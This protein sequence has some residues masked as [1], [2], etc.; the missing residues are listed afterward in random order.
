MT[1]GRIGGW[2]D[3]R[4][5][6]WCVAWRA[7]A[8]LTALLSAYPPI[9]LSAQ[10]G[11]NPGASPYHDLRRGAMVR[12]VGGYLGGE[13]GK[14]PV[15]ASHGWTGG[16]RF[17]YQASNVIIFT[18]GI[19]YARTDAFYVTARESP[20]DTVGPVNSALVLADAGLQISLTGGKTFHGLQP[21]IGGTVGLAFGSPIAAD[22]S[23]YDFG[24]KVTAGPEAG[25]RWY[26]GR[27]VSF[28]L[29]GRIVYYRLQYPAIYRLA[30]LPP[31]A[32]LTEWTAHP[33][34]TFGVAWTF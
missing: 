28:E 22:T 17:E 2:A 20:P 25:I 1:D 32:S 19:A 13:R 9:R 7:V 3:R 24:T 14:V 29:G 8:C 31:N 6:G 4:I 15:G 27:R 5:G 11:H 30:L 21:Y 23:G 34:A 16:L 12:L 26:P 33:W 10:V 18:T